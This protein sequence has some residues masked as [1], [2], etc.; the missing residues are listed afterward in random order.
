MHFQHS[1]FALAAALSLTPSVCASTA[2]PDGGYAVTNLN[3]GS[4]LWTSVTDS[5][6]EPIKVHAEAKRGVLSTRSAK[7]AKR[8]ADCW[9]NALDH[10]GVDTALNALRGWANAG[11]T[12]TSDNGP[13]SHGYVSNGVYAYYCITRAHTSGNLDINDVNHAIGEM[14]KKCATYTGS[15]YGWDGSSEIVGK[16]STSQQVC[17]GPF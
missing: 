12:L 10:A 4:Q 16:A 7:F 2:I 14:D 3:D 17:T 5:A 9:G 13:K 11:T 1:L 6:L 8:R 15:W